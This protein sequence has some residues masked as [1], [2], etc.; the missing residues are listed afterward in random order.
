MEAFG[1]DFE[2]L[3]LLPLASHQ[4][5]GLASAVDG[6]RTAQQ[7]LGLRAATASAAEHPLGLRSF[8]LIA[9]AC[10]RGHP[11]DLIH[12]HGIWL[13]P[14]RASHQL[15][16]RGFPTV[17][18]P[19]GMLDPWAWQRRRAL[20][21]LLW[22]AGE[23]R[24]LQG[25]SCLQALSATEASAIRN[26][27]ITAPVALIPNGVSLPDCSPSARAA[28]PPAPWLAKGVPSGVPVLLFLGRF[29]PK[30]GLNPLLLAWE[31]LQV[32]GAAEAWL[33][34]AGFGDG[35]ALAR[36]LSSSPIPRTC[37]VGALQGDAKASALAHAAGF[38]LPSFSEGLPMAALEAMSWALP[39]LLSPACNLPEAF[40]A[41]AAWPASPDVESLLPV[42]ARWTRSVEQDP[43]ELRSMGGA[44]RQLVTERFHWPQ[45]AAQSLDLYRWLLG[46]GAQPGFVS[47]E[48]TF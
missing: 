24:T 13:A 44:G 38:V 20:K 19:H 42:L 26:L 39:C 31:R 6:L 16:R 46:G 7:S 17:L 37:L 2:L 8:R 14:S 33:V 45:V 5:A 27:G 43:G 47:I 21:Q 48:K 22:W 11:V 23:Q 3:H 35:D 40:T 1:L 10:R 34:F 29:H 28:L 18:A 12:S 9:A 41:G 25:A 30:K 32:Q 4:A 15:R 36:R